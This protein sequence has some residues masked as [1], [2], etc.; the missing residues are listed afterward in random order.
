MPVTGAPVT[1]RTLPDTYVTNVASSSATLHA[2]LNAEGSATTYRFQYGPS[3][4]YGS[5]TPEAAVGS[6]SAPV[7]VEFHLQNLSAASVYHYRVIASNAASE[8][9]A[10]ED[11]TFTTH[12][13]GSEFSLPDGRQYEMVSPPDK[14]AGSIGPMNELAG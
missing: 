11:H 4:E 1:F 3:G 9:F 12:A 5:E 6:G 8:T 13:S 10:S 2:V 7:N 14:Y